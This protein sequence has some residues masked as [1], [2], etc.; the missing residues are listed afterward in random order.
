MHI[1]LDKNSDIQYLLKRSKRKSL[2][3]YVRDQIVEVRAPYHVHKEEIHQ[4]VNSKSDWIT[5]RLLEQQ[6]KAQEKP[7]IIHGKHVLFFGEKRDLIIKA[8]NNN[9]NEL[10]ENITITSRLPD[11]SSYNQALLEKWLKREAQLYLTERVTELA[12]IMDISEK[13]TEL[14]FRKTK[15]KWGHCSSSGQLQFNWLIIM[16][17]ADVIDYLIIHELSHLSH[18]N[19][20]KSFWN[21]VKQFCPNYNIH[22]QWLNDE[23]HRI[24]L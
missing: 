1:K 7:D 3:L 14:R 2:G 18:M 19:H 21:R 5:S 4:W 12:L 11:S 13:I 15:S 24:T 17:P 16:A 8:G 23:G 6:Q 22:R 10:A 20:S 9:V